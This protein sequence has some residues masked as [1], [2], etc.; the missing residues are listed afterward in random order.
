MSYLHFRNT[1]VHQILS[2]EME[3]IGKVIDLLIWHKSLISFEFDYSR[4]PV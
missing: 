3:G 1:L 2:C 4:R